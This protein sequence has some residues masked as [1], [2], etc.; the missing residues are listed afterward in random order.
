MQKI[1]NIVCSPQTKVDDIFYKFKS[2]AEIDNNLPTMV[3]GIENAKGC[4]ENF[5]ILEKIYDNGKFRWTF[6]KNERRIDYEEDLKQFIDYCYNNIISD[7][8]YVYIDLI[9][10]SLNRIKKFIKYIQNSNT[11]YCYQMFNENFIFIYDKEYKTVYGLSLSLCEYIGIKKQKVLNKLFDN[12]NNVEIKKLN[13]FNDNIK[14][15][16]NSNPHYIPP[17]YEYF[18]SN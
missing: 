18:V 11:K 1:G 16:I 7:I 14:H 8:K 9:K 2:C 17:F 10:Y 15:I 3:I 4:I 13:F 12:K 5:S 6:K